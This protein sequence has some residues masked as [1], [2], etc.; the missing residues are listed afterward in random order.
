MLLKNE[1]YTQVKDKIESNHLKISGE[2][3]ERPWGGFF[4]IADK[5][6]N[7]F[8]NIYFDGRELPEETKDLALSPKFLVVEP[9]KKLSWQCHE[10]RS[11]LWRV[12]SGPVGIYKSLTDK[13]PVDMEIHNDSDVIEM[14][15]GTRH[16]RIR[17]GIAQLAACRVHTPEVG[18][19][20]P[21]PATRKHH[22][23][24]LHHLKRDTT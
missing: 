6:L 1:I 11:E 22:E 21:S 5:S 16:R 15:L 24:K 18:G 14:E 8:L 3:F 2:D 10:R 20:N 19:S 4:K 13:Q 9:G 17:S 12:V 23:T 7:D